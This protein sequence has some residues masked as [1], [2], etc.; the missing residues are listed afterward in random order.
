MIREQ[1]NKRL[2]EKNE[3]R[4][5][6]SWHPSKLGNCLT[7]VYLER[8][9]VEP[10]REFDSQTLL[11]FWLGRTYE[12]AIADLLSDDYE[13]QVPVKWL[14]YDISGKIDTLY[15]IDG[16]P[17]EIKSTNTDAFNRIKSNGPQ[18]QHQMQLWVYL[19]CLEKPEGNLM[20]GDRGWGGTEEFQ[21]LLEDKELEKS[22]MEEL[23]ILKSAW[24][25]KLPPKPR[26]EPWFEKYCRWHKS[27]KSQ[28]KYL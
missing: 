28:T 12:K 20:Y 8:A 1:I 17:H 27:C 11:N 9:G 13:W 15:L 7:G 25:N 6:T 4:P 24:E 3:T 18:K 22:V 14:E 21:V 19:K 5:V 2:K 16:M 23:E 26:D 10:D